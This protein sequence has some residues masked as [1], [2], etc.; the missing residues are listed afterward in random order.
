MGKAKEKLQLIQYSVSLLLRSSPTLSCLFLI[1]ITLQGLLPTLSV[2]TSIHLGNIISSADHSGLT[3]VAIL[4]A[5]TFV[6]PGVLAPVISTLQSI[7]NSKATFLTQRKIMEAACRIDDLMLIE[8]PDLHDDLEVLSRE[9]A[10]RPLNLLVNLI[11]IFRGTLTLLSLSLVL[12]SVV[13]W[14]P[15]AFLLPLVP[16]TFAVAYSQIDI[17]KAMLG[18]GMPARRIKYFL[19]VLLDVKLAKEIRLFN[20]SSFFLDKHRQSFNELEDELNQVR[21]KQLM[22]PQPWNLLYLLC[23]L[24]VMFWFVDYLSTGKIS[25][26]GLLG[27]IQSISF[28]GLSCQWMVY[29]FANV[30]VCF[31]FFARLKALETVAAAPQAPP[32]EPWPAPLHEI[33]FEDVSFAYQDDNFVLKNINL[34][35]RAGDHLAIVGENGAGKS[36]LIKLLCRLYHPTSG[37]I[38]CNGTD[39][40]RIDIYQWR[41]QLS[42]IFQDFGHYNLNIKENVTFTHLST[43]ETE[44][45]FLDAC[46]K[47]QFALGNGIA[48]DTLIG[49]EYAGTELSGGQWQ[50]LAL[51][52]ALYTPGELI[53]L[54]EPTSA[55]DPRVEAEIFRQFSTLVHGKTAVMVTHRL[56]VVKHASYLIVLKQGEIVERGTPADLEQARGEYY[57]L[58]KLQREQYQYGEDK[59]G[60]V[61]G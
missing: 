32:E 48:P 35:L 3:T 59:E 2:M 28:F 43:L 15:L 60:D 40:A 54:D 45:G 17:F 26:G 9:A 27:T 12:A 5:L 4:W 38:T 36:T 56:G 58:L 25:V 18:K 22:R 53:I 24:G 23:S 16:V 31:G 29:S 46:A 34:T 33:R 51:A 44:R 39:I 20:L 61:A 11:D 52:R 21:R 42:A 50:R 8:S 47:A 57:S 37:R 1:L 49:K 41:R 13:W 14:L 19:S 55:M 6:I 7:L 10:H 30:G